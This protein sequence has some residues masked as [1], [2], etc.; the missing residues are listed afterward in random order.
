MLGLPV[1][2]VCP[3]NAGVVSKRI[4]IITFLRHY[5]GG[6]ILVFEPHCGRRYKIPRGIPSAEVLNTRGLDNLRV[7]TEIAVYLGNSTGQADSYY[8]SL[9]GS[10][11]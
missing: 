10:P 4:H 1:P 11:R 9:T 5:S 3:Y 8:G 6:I 2:S 7:S